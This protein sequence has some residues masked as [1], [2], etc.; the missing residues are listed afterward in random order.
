MTAAPSSSAL[1]GAER[2]IAD[3]AGERCGRSIS[4]RLAAHRAGLEAI[5]RR[6]GWSFLAHHTDRPAAE[7]LLALIMRMQ[8]A[9][10]TIAGCARCAAGGRA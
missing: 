7:P 1:E 3:R 2:W 9:A 4:E 10:G 8:S 6:L 5:A